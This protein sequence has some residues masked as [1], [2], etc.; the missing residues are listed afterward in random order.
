MKIRFKKTD[1]AAIL[2]T[3]G[4]PDAAGLDLYATADTI[5]PA[6]GRGI[7]PVGLTLAYCEKG[8]WLAI[9]MRSSKRFKQDL[10]TEGV[11][12]SDYRGDLGVKVWNQG[13]TDQKIEKGERFA[14]LIPHLQPEV[15]ISEGEIEQTERGENGIGSTGK[16]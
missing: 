10:Y 11:I 5:I 14:Q 2:P 12:D 1:E 4:T 16:F 7:I 3:K 6:H 9:M 8:Y 15:E 13:D